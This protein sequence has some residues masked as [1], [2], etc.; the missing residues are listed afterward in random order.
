[1]CAGIKVKDERIFLKFIALFKDEHKKNSFISLVDSIQRWRKKDIES[2][3]FIDCFW[4]L[5]KQRMN[6]E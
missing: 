2:Q 6:K 5:E 1:M 4:K 3:I